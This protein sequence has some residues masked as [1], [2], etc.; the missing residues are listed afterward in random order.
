M[1]IVKKSFIGLLIAATIYGGIQMYRKPKYYS[2]VLK[3]TVKITLDS[4]I[5]NSPKIKNDELYMDTH[6]HIYMPEKYPNG[7]EDIVDKVMEKVDIITVMLHEQGMDTLGLETFKKKVEENP[8]YEIKDY[9]KYVE[10]KTE[11]DKLIA[12]KAQELRDNYGRDVLAIGCDGLIGHHPTL[13]EFV[14]EIHKRN[15]IAIIAHPMTINN[16]GFFPFRLANKKEIK[17]LEN[18]YY[19]A[20]SIEEF[21]SQNYLWMYHSNILAEL[22]S[23]EHNILGT[24]GS[25]THGDLEQIGLSG[26]IIKANL[27]G[28]DNL[29]HDLKNIVRNK[30]FRIHK[31]YTNPINFAKEFAIPFLQNKR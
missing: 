22:F 2:M 29:I 18:I 14:E 27:L 5:N 28:M 3:E 31:E 8:K 13:R 19:E 11:N 6:M 1:G 16:E 24:A 15:G 10:V 4:V 7:I 23:K 30:K 25:D 12:I 21:N 9:G 26:I 20:D 17:N